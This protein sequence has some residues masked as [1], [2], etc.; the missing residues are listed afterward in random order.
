MTHKIWSLGAPIVMV[1]LMISSVYAQ[2]TLPENNVVE[3]A[4][5]CS[6]ESCPCSESCRCADAC[7]C[8]TTGCRGCC[9]M[10]IEDENINKSLD[11]SCVMQ[12]C[13]CESGCCKTEAC[14]Q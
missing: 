7:R 3:I 5:R 10:N 11:V 6:E 8:R 4:Q 14:C 13:D 1:S 9:Q 2:D 12:L